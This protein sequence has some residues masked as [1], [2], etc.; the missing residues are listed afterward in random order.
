MVR[1][2]KFE[3]LEDEFVDL[4]DVF[5]NSLQNEVLEIKKLNKQSEKYKHVC[6]DVCN[7]LDEAE[8]VIFSKYMSKEFHNLETFIFVNHTGKVVC[9]LSGRE[10]D[11]YNMI[12]DCNNLKET[13]D[14]SCTHK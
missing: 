1:H 9:N 13:E 3:N 5:K 6:K 2:V 14:Y 10:I 8:Y 11:L 4:P 7:I 12:T